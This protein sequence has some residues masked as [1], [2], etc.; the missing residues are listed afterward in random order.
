MGSHSSLGLARV[1]VT[2]FYAHPIRFSDEEYVS[3]VA[4]TVDESRKLI[5]AG[6]E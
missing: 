4:G 1:E 2:L 3:A 5:E 6:Y